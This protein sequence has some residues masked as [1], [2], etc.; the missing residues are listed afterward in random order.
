MVLVLLDVLKRPSFADGQ[1][2]QIRLDLESGV[3]DSHYRTFSD[4]VMRAFRPGGGRLLASTR[5]RSTHMKKR[6]KW[7]DIKAGMKPEVRA[8]AEAE[9]RELSEE[10]DLNQL[11]KAKGLTQEARPICWE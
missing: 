11:R 3:L 4:V 5:G 1:R 7:A 10:L 6:H 8:R 9:A 2:T